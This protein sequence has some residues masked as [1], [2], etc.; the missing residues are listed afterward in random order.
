MQDY[1]H[2]PRESSRP[3]NS[4]NLAIGGSAAH[5]AADRTQPAGDA[6]DVGQA[7]LPQRPGF[8]ALGI[9][10]KP[11]TAIVPAS[12]RAAIPGRNQ[13]RPIS[14]P[15]RD[16]RNPNLLQGVRKWTELAVV[17][18]TSL[19]SRSTSRTPFSGDQARDGSHG[20]HHSTAS[21][22]ERDRA[23]PTEPERRSAGAPESMACCAPQCP[24]REGRSFG[25]RS[26]RACRPGGRV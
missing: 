26:T 18:T 19:P 11:S 1:E 5:A 20:D 21:K 4:I 22:P 9:S 10:E 7:P 12:K 3:G 15:T 24:L 25:S 17:Q 6:I 13:T 16:R 2:A 23:S 14:V 8:R